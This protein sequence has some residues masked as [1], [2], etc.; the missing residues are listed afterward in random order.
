MTAS[1]DSLCLGDSLFL[2]SSVSPLGGVYTWT[3]GSITAT[4]ELGYLP[5]NIGLNDYLLSYELNG[6]AVED[7]ISVYISPIP[8]VN[9]T[10]SAICSGDTSLL[11]AT[12]D[13]PGG[14]FEWYEGTSQVGTG[15]FLELTPS[16]TT[17]YSVVYTTPEILT[18]A[19]ILKVSDG[20]IE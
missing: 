17:V 18:E 15:A 6:C 5:D 16:D 14:S 13:I 10:A 3:P 9:A 19:L 12:V 11:S 20:Q 7:S 2:S 1:S 4:G 8:L